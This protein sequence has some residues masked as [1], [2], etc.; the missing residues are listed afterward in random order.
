MWCCAV[1][2]LQLIQTIFSRAFGSRWIFSFMWELQFH[3]TKGQR[4]KGCYSN[5]D[6]S[7]CNARSH[8]S[9]QD[10]RKTDWSGWG[11]HFILHR[12]RWQSKTWAK[13]QIGKHTRECL[14]F[15]PAPSLWFNLT[16]VR[17]Y[18]SSWFKTQG[19]AFYKT[20]ADRF[21]LSP[22]Q[23]SCCGRGGCFMSLIAVFRSFYGLRL[24]FLTSSGKLGFNIHPISCCFI[25]CSWKTTWSYGP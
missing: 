17:C 23:Q 19:W 1:C 15:L 7:S 24:I 8:M 22:Q 2:S 12:R 20:S 10:E 21:L 13:W 5:S 11:A 16:T 18:L 3:F 9:P 6:S 14:L 4:I 25:H